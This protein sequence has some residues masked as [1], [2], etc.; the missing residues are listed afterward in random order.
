MDFSNV[1]HEYW[2]LKEIARMS[3][4]LHQSQGEEIVFLLVRTFDESTVLML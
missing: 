1:T 2:T 4:L 3:D